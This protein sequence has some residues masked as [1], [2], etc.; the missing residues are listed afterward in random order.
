MS[1]TKILATPVAEL[2]HADKI[3]QVATIVAAARKAYGNTDKKID[4]PQIPTSEG[5]MSLEYVSDE[6][7]VY[8]IGKE[9][10]QIRMAVMEAEKTQ[11]GVNPNKLVESMMATSGIL[12]NISN[13]TDF[14]YL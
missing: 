10:R 13:T 9:I 6:T 4:S 12:A 3:L 14:N 11:P 2:S 5:V 7:K 1:I 8:L